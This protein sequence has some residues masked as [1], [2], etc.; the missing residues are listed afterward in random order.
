MPSSTRNFMLPRSLR[1]RVV[2]MRRSIGR[3]GLWHGWRPHQ[4]ERLQSPTT[5]PSNSYSTT[6]PTVVKG[7]ETT[8]QKECVGQE[9]QV[10]S[11][12][13]FGGSTSLRE[14]RE[15]CLWRSATWRADWLMSGPA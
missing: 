1:I 4:V 15:V 3:I 10:D 12:G 13:C 5:A 11:H 6:T 9:Y 2:S 8:S 14:R 7:T